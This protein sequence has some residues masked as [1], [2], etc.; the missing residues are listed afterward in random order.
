MFT[1]LGLVSLSWFKSHFFGV[2]AM[3]QSG[4]RPGS[5]SE[6]DGRPILRTLQDG[7]TDSM[8]WITG[9][10]DYVNSMKER[11][12]GE[13]H[14]DEEWLSKGFTMISLDRERTVT[15]APKQG[16]SGVGGQ[17]SGGPASAASRPLVAMQRNLDVTTSGVANLGLGSKTAH[18]SQRNKDRL[19]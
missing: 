12:P 3:S 7:Q 6:D 16:T 4:L 19:F 10:C 11:C 1:V 18:Q 9:L 14:P 17:V 2:Q 5:S 15:T 8:D 13:N